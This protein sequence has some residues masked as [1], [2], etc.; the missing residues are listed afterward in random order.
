MVK[1]RRKKNLTLYVE[2][3]TPFL[4]VIL[5]IVTLW[6]FLYLNNQ[7]FELKNTNGS[8][9]S[10]SYAAQNLVYYYVCFYKYQIKRSVYQIYQTWDKRQIPTARINVL[11]YES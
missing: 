2:L 6:I 7:S 5:G 3:S 10:L 1:W 9:S 4:I 8:D 11:N